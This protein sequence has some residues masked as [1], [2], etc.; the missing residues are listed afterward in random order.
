MLRRPNVAVQILRKQ[1]SRV[2]L[3]RHDEYTFDPKALSHIVKET[4]ICLPNLRSQLVEL[5]KKLASPDPAEPDEDE[6]R[7]NARVPRMRG[8]LSAPD[9]TIATRN[10]KRTSPEPDMT[11]HE[12]VPSRDLALD[13]AGRGVP[14]HIHGLL[15]SNATVKTNSIARTL[16]HARRSQLTLPEAFKLQE[17]TYSGKNKDI[18]VE[19]AVR[20][21][22]NNTD[23]KPS[24][25]HLRVIKRTFQELSSRTMGQSVRRISPTS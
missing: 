17:L 23:K 22:E 21:Y 3:R 7:T 19:V 8:I 25:H 16:E 2:Y 9:S 1:F 4:L 11:L 18:M 6:V 10:R 14:S 15:V 20:N 24:Q 13:D 5:S 12:D